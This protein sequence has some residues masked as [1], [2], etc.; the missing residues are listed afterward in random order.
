VTTYRDLDY[1]S[2]PLTLLRREDERR[3]RAKAWR[4]IRRLDRTRARRIWVKVR[5]RE[6]MRLAA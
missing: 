3:L 5:G 6:R 2:S 4:H 1:E